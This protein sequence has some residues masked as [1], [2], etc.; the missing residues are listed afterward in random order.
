MN[1]FARFVP[2]TRAHLARLAA[3]AGSSLLALP[4]MAQTGDPFADVMTDVTAKVTTYGGALAVL[5]GV[6]VVFYLAIK[7][8]KKI[9]KAA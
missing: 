4:A 7:F 9:P 8:V 6:S 2:S 1:K 3:V 5:A